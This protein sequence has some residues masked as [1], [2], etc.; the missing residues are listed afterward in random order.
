MLQIQ[1][2]GTPVI[3]S[4]D[5]TIVEFTQA[6]VVLRLFAFL[7]MH[8]QQPQQRSLVAGT[9]WPDVAEERARRNLNNVFW[10]LRTLL[11]NADHFFVCDKQTIQFTLPANVWLYVVAFDQA[12]QTR[13]RLSA[14][15]PQTGQVTPACLAEFEQALAL[16]RGDFLTGIDDEWCLMHR[17]QWRERYINTLE[18]FV[19]YCQTCGELARALPEAQQLVALEPDRESV[20]QHLI[21]LYM[22]LEQPVAARTQFEQYEQRWRTELCLPLSAAMLQLASRF[23]F[24]TGPAAA[25]H[26]VMALGTTQPTSLQ[27]HPEY[28]RRQLEI[29][30]KNDELYDLMADR[31][32]Q[33]ENLLVAQALVDQLNAPTAQIDI[34]ARR[35][36]L[37]TRQGAYT[38]SLALAQIGLQLCD[39]TKENASRAWLHRLLGI[40]TEEMGNFKASLHHYTKALA[41]DEAHHVAAFMPANLNN[42]A[43][44]Q[45]TLAHYC[46]AIQ[47]LE[48]AHALLVANA[49]PRV[50]VMVLGN[51]GY[52]WLKLGQLEQA[53]D[54]L[55]R[56]LTLAQRIG[57]R[58]AEW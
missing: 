41:F 46:P 49:I 2:L 7:V 36:W 51:W 18:K 32:S 19:E 27:A 8:R 47:S 58:G 54:Y 52:G 14:N 34:L 21:E 33:G 56:A 11:P 28:L 15:R 3:S 4:A 50:E 1:F 22:G 16:Y 17:T 6:P 25:I 53:G 40:A 26:R 23:G 13:A 43:A 55:P 12:T 5:S 45:L 37:A 57:D 35:A 38:E 24:R 9:F 30:C 48:R 39:T 20:H 44:A 29:C 42:V 31:Q 10:R